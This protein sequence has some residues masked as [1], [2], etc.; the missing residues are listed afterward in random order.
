MGKLLKYEFKGNYKLFL[1]TFIGA[2]LLNIAALFGIDN[3][4]LRLGIGILIWV[5]L[6]VIVLILNINSFKRELYEE[7]GYLTFTLPVGG[8]KFLASKMI[9]AFVWFVIS[10][11]LMMI[12]LGIITE[13]SLTKGVLFGMKSLFYSKELM[14]VSVF[15]GLLYIFTFILLIYFSITITRVGFKSGKLSGF[16]GFI[17]FIAMNFVIARLQIFIMRIMPLNLMIKIKSL[18]IGFYGDRM[19]VLNI[20]K[21]TL[22]SIG[23]GAINLNIAGTIFSLLIFVGL[24]ITTS[25]LIERKID[26]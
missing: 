1:A 9:A 5:V 8:K 16:I 12:S 11:V 24:F 22:L 2:I 13:A 15:T 18:G 3:G 19:E 7:R 26:L 17:V 23:N 14:I 20:G 10:Y 21:S 6:F 4:E 25:Y